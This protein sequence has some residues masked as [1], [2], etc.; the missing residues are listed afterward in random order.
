MKLIPVLD[1]Q[2]GQVVHAIAGQRSNY[3]P[4]VSR[5]TTSTQPDAVAHALLTAYTPSAL[6]VADLDAITR[7]T[8][9]PELL[10]T[11]ARLPLP[12]WL[13]AGVRTVAEVRAVLAAGVWAVVGAETLTDAAELWALCPAE[14]SR[15]LFSCDVRAGVLLGTVRCAQVPTDLAGVIVLDLA[16]VGTGTGVG[17]AALWQGQLP[18]AQT[19]VGGGM[20][21]WADFDD[22]SAA[23]VTGGLVASALHDGRMLPRPGAQSG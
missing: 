22:L 15:V 12:V 20:A 8:P 7:H 3:R 10:A 16:R 23:G 14:R 9:T 18:H 17:T 19:Y 1:V 11:L 2:A 21:S 6:Y 4:L 5:W 13:D